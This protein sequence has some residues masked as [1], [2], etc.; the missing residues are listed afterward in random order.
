MGGERSGE[1]A[2]VNLLYYALGVGVIFLTKLFVNNKNDEPVEK[3]KRIFEVPTDVTMLAFMMG[4][5]GTASLDAYTRGIQAILL[6]IVGISI[7]SV[8]LYKENCSL[9]SSKGAVTQ[10]ERSAY[11][12]FLFI[13]NVAL[14]ILAVIL[15]YEFLGANNS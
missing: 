9:I 4:I 1:R 13:V 14:A 15:S 3:W 11:A 10:I 2:R 12:A 6:I 7:A 8:A 5:A